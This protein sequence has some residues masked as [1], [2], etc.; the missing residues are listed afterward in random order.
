[1]KKFQFRLLALQKVRTHERDACQQMLGRLLAEDQKLLDQIEDIQHDQQTMLKEIQ[2]STQIGTIDP[3]MV[4]SRRFY[5]GQLQ[6]QQRQLQ[7]KRQELAKH[8]EQARL[9]LADAEAKVKSLERLKEE[10]YH[11]HLAEGY[12]VAD[13]EMEEAW[14]ARHRQGESQ[15]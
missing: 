9:N 10:Q 1:M 15:R 12:K 5:L 11:E 7:A 4:A 13:Q 14:M 6:L 8:V 2:Q 3:R